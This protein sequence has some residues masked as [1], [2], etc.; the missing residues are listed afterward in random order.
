M[1]PNVTGTLLGIGS[2]AAHDIPGAGKASASS[3][4]SA[5][6]AN[7]AGSIFELVV[8]LR[9][10]LRVDSGA[11]CS[12]TSAAMSPELPPSCSLC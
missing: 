7:S 12:A 11:A 8:R 6:M 5:S 1:S 10:D 4:T 3:S 9:S 2:K